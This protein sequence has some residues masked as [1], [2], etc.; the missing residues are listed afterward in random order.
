MKGGT[1]AKVFYYVVKSAEGFAD[2]HSLVFRGRAR[3][4]QPI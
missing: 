1:Q 4:G 2:Y 3:G